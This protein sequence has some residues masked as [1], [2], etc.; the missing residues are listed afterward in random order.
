MMRSTVFAGLVLACTAPYAALA[1]VETREVDEFSEIH[2]ML[3]FTV[4][5]VLADEHYVELDGDEDTIDEITTEVRGDTLKIYKENSWFDWSDGKVRITVGYTELEALT[6][7]GS[8]DGFVE[9]L[10]ND[11][12][13]L[14]VTGSA[15]LE[16]ES[17]RAD[18]VYLSIAGSGNVE[19]EDAQIDTI[20]SKINGSGDIAIS[21]RAVAQEISISGSGD[22][23][24]EDLRTQETS[25]TVRGSGDVRVWAESH[26]SAS[27]VGSGDI[28]YYGAPSVK[29]R[30]MGSGS[31]IQLSE[32][33]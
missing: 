12:L 1:D 27:V 30:V 4:D 28:E 10:E 18:E 6:M 7:A 3:P 19:I 26:L 2:Y 14:K 25:A 9:A 21:G 29:E 8:G 22:H 24:A 16:I 20:E 15:N 11:E 5:F 33:R 23:V 31:I 32:E 17:L 13:T